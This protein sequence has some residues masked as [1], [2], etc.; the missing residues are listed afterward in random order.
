MKR[1]KKF[2]K[3]S[4]IDLNKMK[5]HKS[6]GLN[7]SKCGRWVEPVSIDTEEVICHICTCLMA[8]I[9]KKIPQQSS[10]F[11]RGWKM[12]GEFVH[13]D[14][15]VFHRGVEM[16]ELKGTLPATDLKKIKEK[17]LANKKDKKTREAKKEAKLLKQYEKKQELKKKIK[18]KLEKSVVYSDEDKKLVDA[19]KKDITL[20]V[21]KDNGNIE[22]VDSKKNNYTNIVNNKQKLKYAFDSGKK[23]FG[24]KKNNT[25]KWR[26]I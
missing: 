13:E 24:I 4:T 17:E 15:R 16:P 18:E 1:K 14:G 25:I 7:C 12:Y 22:A 3:L 8:P 10:G 26:V 6:K 21:I 20:D 11:P 2:E 9:E 5:E 19:I 23:I